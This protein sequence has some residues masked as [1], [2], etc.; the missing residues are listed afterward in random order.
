MQHPRRRCTSE[1]RRG[2]AQI[3]SVRQYSLC[4][5]EHRFLLADC[6]KGRN[7]SRVNC[8]CQG[9]RL[10]RRR[11]ARTRRRYGLCALARVPR[12]E[13][14]RASATPA[15]ACASK[16]A[17]N[18]SCTIRFASNAAVVSA[19]RAALAGQQS[20]AALQGRGEGCPSTGSTWVSTRHQ[21]YPDSLTGCLT[22]MLHSSTKWQPDGKDRK[23]P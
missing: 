10:S 15:A 4:K 9:L 1:Y 3:I 18:F 2:C 7:W 5:R 17:A 21:R 14:P 11:L 20:P 12:R 8:Q 6:R 23:H 13:A 16:N 22:D 19:R